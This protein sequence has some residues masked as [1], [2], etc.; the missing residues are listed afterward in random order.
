MNKIIVFGDSISYGKWDSEGGWVARLRKYIDQKYNLDKGGNALVYN[1]GIPG[2]VAIRMSKRVEDE[3]AVRITDPGDKPLI[4][5]AVG[6]NDSCPNNWMTKTQT[7]ESEFKQVLRDIIAIAQKYN[8]TPMLIGLTPVNSSKS[9]GL[10]FTNE[11]VKRYDQ[12]ISQVASELNV[13]N[14][15]LFE[16]L[17][18]LNFS[19]L[20]VDSVHPNS[21]GH[22]IMTKLIISSLERRGLFDAV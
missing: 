21:H 20:L 15:D 7:P 3:L 6:I 10:L 5:F 8:C 11:S 13:F 17:E 22:E 9:K 2:E 18:K 12:Y 19:E 1:L 16:E 14:V 4:L